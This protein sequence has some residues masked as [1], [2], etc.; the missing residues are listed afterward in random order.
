MEFVWP[1][2]KMRG[3]SQAACQHKNERGVGEYF[4]IARRLW[5][6]FC[7]HCTARY[8][9]PFDS[10]H[11]LS[12]ANVLMKV[13]VACRRCHRRSA[14]SQRAAHLA[15]RIEKR[16]V[17]LIDIPTCSLTMHY[18]SIPNRF[19]RNASFIALPC[20]PV[21]PTRTR[22]LHGCPCRHQHP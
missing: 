21:L 17:S 12:I 5:S 7:T 4:C 14:P 20:T 22:H 15:C 2:Q 1:L 9:R 19:A 18:S 3:T 10:A 6:P 11:F 13:A 16:P 8:R